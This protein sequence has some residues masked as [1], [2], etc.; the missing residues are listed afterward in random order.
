MHDPDFSREPSF[1]VMHSSL[2]TCRGRGLHSSVRQVLAKARMIGYPRL[3]PPWSANAGTQ[4]RGEANPPACDGTFFGSPI[5]HRRASFVV[6]FISFSTTLDRSFLNIVLSSSPPDIQA[7]ALRPSRPGAASGLL[8]AP[9]PLHGSLPIRV[10]TCGKP[11]PSS[12]SL[13]KYDPSN[14]FACNKCTAA[15]GLKHVGSPRIEGER[16]RALASRRERTAD[17]R[18]GLSDH[19]AYFGTAVSL[20]LGALESTHTLGERLPEFS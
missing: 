11:E 8:S 17:F 19:R 7:I 5:A 3:S 4:C 9:P 12:A 2:T 18:V 14:I 6:A 15:A 13:L 20:W 1:R 10:G 16:E